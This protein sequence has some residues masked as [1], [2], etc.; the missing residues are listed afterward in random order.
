MK[1]PS[2][3]KVVDFGGFLETPSL[4]D[5]GLIS[6]VPSHDYASWPQLFLRMVPLFMN[7]PIFL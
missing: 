6:T 7:Y 3:R 2:H 5:S 4:L 1:T